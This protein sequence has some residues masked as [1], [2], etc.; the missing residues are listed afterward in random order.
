M[1]YFYFTQFPLTKHFRINELFSEFLVKLSGFL[2]TQKLFYLLKMFHFLGEPETP[3]DSSITSRRRGSSFPPF[4][5]KKISKPHTFCGFVSWKNWRNFF[6]NAYFSIQKGIRILLKISI[7]KG[8]QKVQQ[9]LC[10]T[11]FVSKK[12]K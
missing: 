10:E 3:S 2:L 4:F 6:E 1:I 12:Q 11:H 7:V 5:D 8:Y 9:I